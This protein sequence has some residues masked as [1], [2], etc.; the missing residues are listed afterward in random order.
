MV[1]SRSLHRLLGMVML[2]PFIAWA[3][4]GAIF[5][6]K[7]GYADAYDIPQ[8]KTYPLTEQTQ[9]KADP[10]WLEMR[11]LKTILGEH[12]LV[13]TGEGW[14]HLNL[15]TRQPK[16]PPTEDELRQLL[17][18]ALQTTP[19]RYGAIATIN[20]N[21]ATTSTGVRVTLNWQ[22]MTL[23][24]TGKD[25]DRIDTLYKI[26][27]LQWTGIPGIDKVLGAL[28]ITFILILSFLG[29]RLFFSR[30]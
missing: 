23:T 19:E 6:L 14:Q 9:I 8:V 24:Q 28:G 12:L 3:V 5:F 18:E 25:T 2:L 17:N 21:T 13:R 4:T 10:A 26:H 30:R 1:K 7:P 11:L 16:A 27:Y 15:V 20:D 29:L 22:R